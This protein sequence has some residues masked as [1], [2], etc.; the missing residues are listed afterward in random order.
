MGKTRQKPALA[1]SLSALLEALADQ[2]DH[3]RPS[4]ELVDQAVLLLGATPP[5][6]FVEIDRQVRDL[7]RLYHYRYMPDDRIGG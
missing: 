3:Q 6:R 5:S 1:G 7:G 4:T 2:L